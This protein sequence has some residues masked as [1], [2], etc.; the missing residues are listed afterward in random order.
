MRDYCFKK[1]RGLCDALLFKVGPTWGCRITAGGKR[2]GRALSVVS[3]LWQVQRN[4]NTAR[5]TNRFPYH[6]DYFCHKLHMHQNEKLTMYGLTEVSACDSGKIGAFAT[7]LVRNK[8]LIYE[9]IYRYSTI[10][11]IV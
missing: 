10:T 9:H 1:V 3:P 2:N 7:M 5:Q 8:V 6:A 4:S 11:I